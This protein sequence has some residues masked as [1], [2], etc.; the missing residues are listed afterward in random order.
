LKSFIN[1]VF[2]MASEK[3]VLWQNVMGM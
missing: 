3:V 1:P 2:S